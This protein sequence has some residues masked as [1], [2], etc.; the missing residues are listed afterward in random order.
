MQK[1]A[2]WTLTYKL[3]KT[4]SSPLSALSRKG[5]VNLD[6][7]SVHNPEQL[8][9][10]IMQ[11]RLCELWLT[12]CSRPI[13]SHC[14]HHA[15]KASWTLTYN[16]FKT[17]TILLLASCKKSLLNA[18]LLSIQNPEKPIV[19]MQKR[20]PGPWLTFCPRPRVGLCQH[21]AEKSSWTVTY[22]LIKNQSSLL[23]ASCR[24]GA[25]TLTYTLFKNQSV[26][27]MQKRPCGHGPT[28]CSKSR[29][30]IVS[31]MQERT[32][33][34]WLTFCS[35]P[36]AAN[37]QHHIGKASQTLTYKLF[38]TQSRPL[39]ASCRTG[40][41]GADLPPVQKPIVSIMQKSL[42]G[43]WLTNYSKPTVAHC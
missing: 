8:N 9:V 38:K 42:S 25:C 33:V 34:P 20:T 11:K 26:I 37:C 32:P 10:I 36:R 19:S 41:M 35:K 12:F 31:I 4:K 1:K 24:K 21:H 29:A 3:C 18:G 2:S 28:N 16:L 5:F 39:S 23:L 43:P 6:L 14:Q 13:A 30:A 15:E 27:I 40:P 7:L 22:K 17:Q